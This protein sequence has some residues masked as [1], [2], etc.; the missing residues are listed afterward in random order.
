MILSEIP[1]V[2]VALTSAKKE[3]I[4][5]LHRFIFDYDGDR[6][7]RQ[8]IRNFAGFNLEKGSKEYIE[9]L[10]YIG[11]NF[12]YAELVT[13]ANLL[14]IE[15]SGDVGQLADRLLFISSDLSKLAEDL[16]KQNTSEDSEDENSEKNVANKEVQSDI[17][18]TNESNSFSQSKNVNGS[19]FDEC[20]N[21]NLFLNYSDVE[22]TIIKFGAESHENIITWVNHFENMSKLFNLSDVQKFIFAKRSLIGVASLFVRT[23][24][25]INS[26]LKLKNALIKEFSH[27]INSAHLHE[28]LNNRKIQEKETVQE[29]FLK[30]KEISNGQIDDAALIHYIIKGLNDK[31]ENKSILY[32]CK[33]LIEF[34]EKLKVYELIRSDSYQHKGVLNKPKMTYNS[35]DKNHFYDRQRCKDDDVYVKCCNDDDKK[36]SNYSNRKTFCYNCGDKNHISKFCMYKERGSKCFKCKN[37]GH[38][39][40]ECIK[41]DAEQEVTALSIN[42]QPI[43]SKIVTIDNLNVN[44]CID[45]GSQITL[46]KKYVFDKLNVKL[47]PCN[48]SLMGIGKFKIKPL[49]YFK[50]EVK[51]DDFK[52]NA[53]IYVVNNSVIPYDLIIGLNVLMQG[54]TTINENGIFIKNKPVCVEN[55]LSVLPI[56]LSPDNVEV[57]VETNISNVDKDEAQK[58]ILNNEPCKVK[59]ANVELN[60]LVKNKKRNCHKFHKLSFPKKKTVKVKAAKTL[61]QDTSKPNSSVKKDEIPRDFIDVHKMNKINVKGNIRCNSFFARERP[62]KQKSSDE[63]IKRWC[64][65]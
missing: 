52:C 42:V 20:L 16:G 3:K 58:L 35:H 5:I 50:H 7:N 30:M 56:D 61:K 34:K 2:N 40:A 65:T 4:R 31:V 11:E 44:S 54:E 37:F 25:N 22:S 23:E 32:G 43:S 51:I 24:P 28:I 13:I 55:V 19:R 26:W 57:N 47:L 39:S 62:N 60:V 14:E 27:D 64:V 63:Y 8:R 49:G 6:L 9:K 48:T 1:G 15:L 18:A 12:S 10:K 36:R 21:Q 29:Y 17:Y 59:D 46:I 53:E 38:K 33:N 41:I 45:T